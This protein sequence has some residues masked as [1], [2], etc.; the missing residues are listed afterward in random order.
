MHRLASWNF[1]IYEFADLT[2]FPLGLYFHTFQYPDFK[3]YSLH[4]FHCRVCLSCTVDTTCKPH[5][6]AY[7]QWKSCLISTCSTSCTVFPSKLHEWS[8]RMQTQYITVL[9]PLFG[10]FCCLHGFIRYYMYTQRSSA[11]LFFKYSACVILWHWPCRLFQQEFYDTCSKSNDTRATLWD[12]QCFVWIEVRCS[13][14]SPVSLFT[15]IYLFVCFLPKF[16]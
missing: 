4:T 2:I 10:N 13:L 1:L 7:H 9:V 3:N 14:P 12:K 16:P 11:W 5:W 15:C 6:F 8:S